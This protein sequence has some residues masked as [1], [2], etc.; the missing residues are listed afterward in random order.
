MINDITNYF[1]KEIANVR[2]ESYKKGVTDTQNKM[3]K[4]DKVVFKDTHTKPSKEVFDDL[5]EL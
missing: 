5:D 2:K 4:A 1:Q 3:E